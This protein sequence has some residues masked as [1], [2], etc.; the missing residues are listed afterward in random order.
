MNQLVSKNQYLKDYNENLKGT[1]PADV[2]NS[3]PEYNH[4]RNVSK[5]TSKVSEKQVLKA[6][7]VF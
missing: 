2:A 1:A 6:L 3:Y 7:V 4:A 5:L